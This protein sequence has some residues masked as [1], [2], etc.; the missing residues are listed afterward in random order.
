MSLLTQ[1][2]ILITGAVGNLGLATAR[3]AQKAG[4]HTVLLDRSLERLNHTYPDL[5]S[6]SD[7]LFLGGVD[8][9]DEA[10]VS[11]AIEKTIRQFGRI[12]VLVNT[13]GAWRGGT[14]VHQSSLADWT[15]LF[16]LNVRTT[17]LT[18]RA[19]VPYFI[20][21]RSGR[22]INVASRAALVGDAGSAAYSVAKS[23]VLRLTE[24]LS[25]E[26]KEK[27]VNVNCVLRSTIDTPQNRAA[28]PSADPTKWVAPEAIADVIAFLASDAAR[29][30][31]GIALPVFGLS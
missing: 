17:L 4:A 22:I 19:V 14:P 26:L 27:G 20:A 28:M 18:C 8:L 2:V 21:Q 23:G 7:H 10:S 11:A 25:A 30:I 1:R 13:V 6:S 15:S 12:D 3:A 24:S 16:E 29:A 5:V 31:H 9:S